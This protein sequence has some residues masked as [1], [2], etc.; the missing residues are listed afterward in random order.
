MG[1]ADRSSMAANDRDRLRIVIPTY[2]RKDSQVT[3]S[4][5]PKGWRHR[6]TFVVDGRDATSLK[7][8]FGNT[9]AEFLVHPEEIKTIAAKRAWIISQTQWNKVLMLDDD[10]RPCS[11]RTGSGLPTALPEEVDEM[12]TLVENKLDEVVHCGISSRQGNNHFDPGWNR[13]KR[14]MYALG[15]KTDVMREVCELGRIDTREDFDYTLQLLRKG[16]PNEV[17]GFFCVD[18][19]YAKHGGCQAEGRT[20]EKSNADALKLAA[21]HPGLVRIVDK[22]YKTSI[23]RKEVVISWAKAFNKEAVL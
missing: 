9:G 23:P 3:F 6:T 11:R 10:L 14:M 18:Q 1:D 12:F 4:H 17:Y 19:K 13:N 5:I 20:V 16:F 22:E 2:R 8:L 15:Y 21:L 7:L